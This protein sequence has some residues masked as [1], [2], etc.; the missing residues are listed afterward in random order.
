LLGRPLQKSPQG[1][2]EKKKKKNNKQQQ[3]DECGDMR[4]VPDLKSLM[5]D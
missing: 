3:Q 2:E 1:E 4:S 5:I